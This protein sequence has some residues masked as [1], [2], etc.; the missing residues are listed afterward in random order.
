MEN[1]PHIERS[2]TDCAGGAG[3]RLTMAHIG[4]SF[5]GVRVLDDVQFELMSG[6]V[7]ILAGENGAGKSTLIK[8]LAGV[9]AEYDG[10][11]R[12]DGQRVRFKSPQEARNQGI[13]VIY[14]ELSLI[15][16]M[17]VLDNLFLGRETSRRIQV[18][19]AKE[20]CRQLDLEIELDQPVGEYSLAVQQMIEIAK[21]LAG[22]AR[23]IVMDEPTSAL[24][25]V[26]TE[27]LFRIMN[28]L[29]S[30]GRSIIY[31][32]HRIEEIYRVGD[33]I[34]V[35][36]DGKWV[37]T[38][39]ATDLP[40]DGLIRWMVG[41][42]LTQQFPPR[43]TGMGEERLTLRNVSVPQLSAKRKWAVQNV[44]LTLRSGE[45]LGIAGLQGSG[46]SDLLLGLFGAYGRVLSGKVCLGGRKFEVIS[47]RRSIG[48]G[49]AML[50][51][52]RK[53]TGIIPEMS[54]CRNI[55]ISSL[56]R[57]SRGGWI[58][59][60][61]EKAAAEEHRDALAIRASSLDQPLGSLS[62]G[63]QQKV[64]LA[65][66]LE[67]KPQVLLLDEPTR[68]VDVGAKHEIYE[69]MNRW[70]EEG[71]AILLI[72]S[73]MPELLAMSDRILVL[74]RG[75]VTAE[76]TRETA[77]QDNILRAAMGEVRSA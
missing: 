53:E 55:T 24:S 72:T 18:E 14:Q 59:V 57:F 63:N 30:R 39:K 68:G 7:H 52:D 75:R 74:H 61:H 35:L 69:L 31:I 76:Y 64:L 13:S 12:I 71:M 66:W 47:P 42:D 11:V 36:R 48:Q 41:R 38:A 29:R 21:A 43:K 10:E 34:T 44:S 32:T 4:K 26:E 50:T 17:S 8:I 73:E 37:G 3:G 49:M 28:D 40:R 27:K 70:T 33:R 2:I 60:K 58:D 77:T 46:N 5:D 1:Q 51:N 54:V 56:A 9:H 20:I 45:I 6:E 16:P 23:I 67:T 62:G 19:R 65:R 25:D 15:R 22:D